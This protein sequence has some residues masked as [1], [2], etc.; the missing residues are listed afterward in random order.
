MFVVIY[1]KVT[2]DKKDGIMITKPILGPTRDTFSQAEDESRAIINQNRH[3]TVIPRI[4]EIDNIVGVGGI[5][6]ESRGY[7][8]SLY[9]NIV[10]A[11]EAMSRPIHRRRKK[12]IFKKEEPEE[13]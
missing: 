7:F 2:D 8:E 12:K 10:E 3:C 13:S 1:A 6:H 9:K 11:K 5:L 4:Y